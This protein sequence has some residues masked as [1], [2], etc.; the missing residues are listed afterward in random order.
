LDRRTATPGAT[1]VLQ[2]T[3]FPPGHASAAIM[4]RSGPTAASCAISR[5]RRANGATQSVTMPSWR[6]LCL[7]ERGIKTTYTGF[8]FLSIPGSRSVSFNHRYLRQ[9]SLLSTCLNSSRTGML[10]I[11]WPRATQ[12]WTTPRRYRWL[13]RAVAL[14]DACCG[15]GHLR[16]THYYTPAVYFANTDAL[17]ALHW[18]PRFP[19]RK[20]QHCARVARWAH[21]L[22]QNGDAT[23][24]AGMPT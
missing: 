14:C 11:S 2:S 12:P 21:A 13:T 3:S 15:H 19:E 22:R 8:C 1:A 24:R 18:A 16:Y 9:H 5:S 4:R 7:G 20:L 23:L 10:C 6:I 17:P